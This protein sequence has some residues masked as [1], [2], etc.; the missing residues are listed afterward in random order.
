MQKVVLSGTGKRAQLNGYSSAGKT[1]TAWKY[2]EK[3]KKI[4][5]NKFIS[6]FIGFASVDNPS[7]VIAVI[8]DEPQVAMRDGG[9]VSAPIFRS[10]AEQILPELNV[11]PDGTVRQEIAEDIIEGKEF[12]D[13]A[14]GKADEKEKS[15][16]TEKEPNAVN[17]KITKDG[18]G[19]TESKP[20]PKEKSVSLETKQKN[21]TKNKSSGKEK[22]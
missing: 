3:L 16:K 1:G 7:V 8:L 17:P 15:E 2:D 12:K 19:K 4:N 10:I 20:A 9:H 5:E 21:N 22:T 18:K 14:T 6:S 13:T 11:A